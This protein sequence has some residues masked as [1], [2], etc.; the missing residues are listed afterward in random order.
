MKMEICEFNKFTKSPSSSHST[1]DDE[2]LI[3]TFDDNEF[4]N[5]IDNR[6][7]RVRQIINNRE[8]E[9]SSCDRKVM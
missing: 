1:A 8:I 5:L 3:D 7:G 9:H 6:R 2:M 4:G